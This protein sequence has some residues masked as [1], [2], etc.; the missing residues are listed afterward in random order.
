MTLSEVCAILQLWPGTVQ[1]YFNILIL[2]T[3]TMQSDM[4]FYHREA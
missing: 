3:V 1:K 2:S 4:V